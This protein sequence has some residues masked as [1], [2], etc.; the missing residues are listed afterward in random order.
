MLE[1]ISVE[2]KNVILVP[3]D[4]SDLPFSLR[5]ANVFPSEKLI[6]YCLPF[7]AISSLSA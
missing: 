7:R 6:S 2:A 5:G 4:F 3:L 1:K